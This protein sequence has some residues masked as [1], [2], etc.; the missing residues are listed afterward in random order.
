[1]DWLDD[2]GSCTGGSGSSSLRGKID[3]F[4]GVVSELAGELQIG[5]NKLR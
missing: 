3:D 1:M 5:S 2:V 4:S